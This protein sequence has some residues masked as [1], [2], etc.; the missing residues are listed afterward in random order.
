MNH[1]NP[2]PLHPFLLAISPVLFLYSR[3]MNILDVRQLAW[4]LLTVLGFV[5]VMELVL[6]A[7]IKSPQRRWMVMSCSIV[8]LFIYSNFVSLLLSRFSLEIPRNSVIF[9]MAWFFLL[10]GAIFILF[11]LT[12]KPLPNLNAIL[13]VFAVCLVSFSVVKIAAAAPRQYK[14]WKY[15]IMLPNREPPAAG[16]KRPEFC[17]NIYVLLFDQH[18]GD[19]C[20]QKY[21]YDNSVLLDALENRGFY[22]ARQGHSNYSYTHV[23]IASFLN[24]DFLDFPKTGA[25][26]SI[27]QYLDSIRNNN[28]A[29]AFLKQYGYTTVQCRTDFLYRYD[30]VNTADIQL[31][32][33]PWYLGILPQ[34]LLGNTPFYSILSKGFDTHLPIQQRDMN[35]SL[36]RRNILKAVEQTKAMT[37]FEK[38]FILYSH[39]MSPHGPNCF[40][41]DGGF[42]GSPSRFDNFTV[43]FCPPGKE[44]DARKYLAEMTFIDKKIIEIVEYI[45]DHSK[46]PPVIVLMGDHGNRFWINS[47]GSI[48]QA[49][50]E[51]YSIL[52]AM[53]LPNCDYNSTLYPDISLVNTFRVIFNQ[54]FGAGYPLLP[55]RSF[56]P[57]KSPDGVDDVTQYIQQEK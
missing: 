51:L 11:R 54:Y 30:E 37:R 45:Q 26:C 2:W 28:H 13:N 12:D 31:M 9:L 15:G 48:Q 16:L 22:V 33:D 50:P 32:P 20:L 55:D 7:V 19:S 34:E 6:R 52:N 43:N 23:S 24:Y 38:P 5:A 57:S 1:K 40:I 29:F 3:N 47:S 35:V 25:A 10:A 18:V 8:F 21:G 36:L 46:T 41:E 14:L 53:Y 49:A 42:P 17:P 27:E 39:F 56:Y 4:S 44:K